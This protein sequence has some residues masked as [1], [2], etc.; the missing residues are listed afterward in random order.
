MCALLGSRSLEVKLQ[1]GKKLTK[2]P[3][4]ERVVVLTVGWL[5]IDQGIKLAMVETPNLPFVYVNDEMSA[6]IPV[7]D[8]RV[9][10]LSAM[11]LQSH[12]RLLMSW[13]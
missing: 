11:Q 4:M 3:G 1:D 12:V 10:S 7:T 6:I 9:Q 5:R 13:V 2:I 8:T